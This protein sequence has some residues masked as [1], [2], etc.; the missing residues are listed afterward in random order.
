MPYSDYRN[1]GETYFEGE[2]VSDPHPA[3]YDSYY[4]G[5][6]PFGGYAGKVRRELRQKGI[7]PNNITVAVIGCAYGFT[8][9][10]L[11]EHNTD[12][13]GIDISSWAVSNSPSGYTVVQGDVLSS[14]DLK[15]ARQ[16]GPPEIVYNE[17]VLS[18]LTDSEAVTACNNMRSEAKQTVLHR[19]WTTGGSDLGED[20]SE[21]WYNSKTLSEWKNL[22]D[23]DGED[24][25]YSEK[26][27]QQFQ[28]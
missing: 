17:C 7:N 8:V 4:P 27:F 16:G 21:G 24:S 14:S 22:C 23:P 13:Y 28:P 6:L 5:L 26:E 10:E 25:W 1:F 19:V 9:K 2:S 3:G 18:C 11:V 15:N 20:L 12:A